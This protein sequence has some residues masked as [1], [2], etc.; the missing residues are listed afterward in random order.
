MGLDKLYLD[1]N[2]IER[3]RLFEITSRLTD[4]QLETMLSND[5]SVASTLVHLAYWDCYAFALLKEWEKTGFKAPAASIDAIN[6]AVNV[7]SR[8]IPVRDA[9]RLVCD[10]AEAVDRKV[11]TIPSALKDEIVAAD[12]SQFL[13]RFMHRRVHLDRIEKEL[14][15]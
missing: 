11:E 10:M 3:E 9:A 13:C 7:L 8:E 4:E 15:F 5:W 6:E 12:R 2:R 1:E 14:E